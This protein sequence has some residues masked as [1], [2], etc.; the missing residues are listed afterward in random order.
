VDAGP[1][2]APARELHA[3]DRRQHTGQFERLIRAETGWFPHDTLK[4]YDGEPFWP[5]EIAAKVEAV[6]HDAKKVVHQ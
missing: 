6:L 4:K 5:E 2:D 3:D 1:R